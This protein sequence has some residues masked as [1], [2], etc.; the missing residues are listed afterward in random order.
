MPL[1]T[2]GD[3]HVDRPLTMM[4][5]GFVQD[6]AD[7][8][9]GNVFPPIPVTNKSDVYFKY[10]RGDFFRNNMQKRAP[11]TPAAAGGY[12]LATDTYVADVWA[13]KKIIDDQI[14]ANTDSP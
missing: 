4:S 6:Q 8:V 7:F 13:L 14:R 1:P 10:N 9:S 12:K 3:V 11:G 2:L 5:V